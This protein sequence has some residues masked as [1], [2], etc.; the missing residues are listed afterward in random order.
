VKNFC[1]ICQLLF[2]F[3]ALFDETAKPR[4]GDER[5]LTPIPNEIYS[6]GWM[7]AVLP[8]SFSFLFIFLFLLVSKQ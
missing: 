4:R 1:V 5:G 8:I 3:P 6:F 2:W 7:A